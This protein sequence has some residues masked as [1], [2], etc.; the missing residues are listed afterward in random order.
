MPV[1]QTGATGV[2]VHNLFDGAGR[3]RDGPGQWS[4]DIDDGRGDDRE[5]AN[6]TEPDVRIFS[7][8][9][10]RLRVAAVI[11]IV[12]ATISIVVYDLPT[13][14][15]GAS[16]S[17]DPFALV[18]G[19]F[20]SD[21][22]ALIAAYGALR[23]QR[24]GVIALVVVQSFWALQ[25]GVALIDGEAVLGATMLC[26]TLFCIWCCLAREDLPASTRAAHGAGTER[27]HG[28]R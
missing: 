8:R 28:V 11:S 3:C 26:V 17:D 13:L 15:K 2:D 16:G 14:A 10:G 25:A 1:H 18:V 20:A 24:W 23:R 19:S 6:R 12:V 21:V 5:T 9:T 4:G 7:T 22:V 27:T